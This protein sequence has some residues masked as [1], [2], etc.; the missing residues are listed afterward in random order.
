MSMTAGS[1]TVA[2]DASVVKS[3]Y[4]GD[5]F[6]ALVLDTKTRLEDAGMS[7]PTDPSQ[8]APIYKGLAQQCNEFA[9]LIEYIQANAEAGGD[10][11]T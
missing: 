6:D 5:R 11:V 7:M 9:A 4:A 10:P 3:G 2:D 1:V 8:L